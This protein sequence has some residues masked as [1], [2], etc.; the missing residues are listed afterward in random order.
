MRNP[1][2]P[3]SIAAAR[4]VFDESS[5][6]DAQHQRLY[7]IDIAERTINMFSCG[8]KSTAIYCAAA[9]VGALALIDRHNPIFTEGADV[10]IFD[11]TRGVP[12][13][14]ANSFSGRANMRF[15]DGACNPQGRFTTGLMDERTDG[16]DDGIYRFDRALNA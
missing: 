11:T 6:W 3:Y 4:A 7:F 2:R 14:R 8:Q 5:V 12:N 16:R 1:L 9:P 13:K 10:A 15:N